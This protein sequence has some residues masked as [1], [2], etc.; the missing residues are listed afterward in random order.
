MCRVL[1]ITTLLS[2]NPDYD[3]NLSTYLSL[4][5]LND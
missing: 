4:L 1:I 5:L 2:K 3:Q